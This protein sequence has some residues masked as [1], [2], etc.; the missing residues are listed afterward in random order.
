MGRMPYGAAVLSTKF[1]IRIVGKGGR[2]GLL[3]Y[4]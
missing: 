1:Q 4:N 2:M 3:F